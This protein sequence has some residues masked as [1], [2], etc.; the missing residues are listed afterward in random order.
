[1]KESLYEELEHVYDQFP[2]H[3]MNILLKDFNAKARTDNI[4]KP[5]TGNKSLYEIS[6]DNGVRVVNLDTS[7]NITVMSTMFL[8]HKYTQT[9]ADGKMHNQTDYIL[10][11][12]QWYSSIVHVQSFR[13]ADCDTGH[14]LLVAEERDRER[15]S[16]SK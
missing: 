3:P 6:N 4:S 14:Y 11:D 7:E 5:T 1:M 9:S 13:V 16:I 2:K 8:H 10:T 15:M 12:K